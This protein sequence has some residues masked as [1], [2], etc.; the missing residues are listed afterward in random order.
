MIFDYLIF[1]RVKLREEHV[2][3]FDYPYEEFTIYT[4]DKE[5][6][7]A[8]LFKPTT[9]SK[10]LII[11]FHGNAD[12]LQRWGQY[13]IDFT[14]LGYE[15]LMMDY[16]GYGK[17]TGKP[18]EKLYYKDARTVWYWAKEN[19]EFNKVVLFGRSLGS[20]MASNLAMEVNPDLLILETPFDELKGAM[21]PV[22]RRMFSFFSVKHVF[23]TKAHLSQV[24][25]PK[26]VLHGTNDR[27]VPLD[28]ALKL[29]SVLADTDQFIIIPNAK[30]GNLRTFDLYHQ[31]LS[32]V[33][34]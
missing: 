10:G 6:I 11:Y 3:T 21:L 2:F 8:L 19:I 25:C 26:M 9:P 5:K 34:N 16:R 22:V 7:N 29:K 18:S 33:L 27:V 28:S 23:P 24:I 31:K 4:E 30:H 32:E 14:K 15:I 1:Q 13:A 20:A 12:N 17:S